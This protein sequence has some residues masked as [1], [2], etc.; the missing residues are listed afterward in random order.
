MRRTYLGPVWA[1]VRFDYR[2]ALRE[3]RRQAC[4]QCASSRFGG[5]CIAYFGRREGWGFFFRGASTMLRH[6][7]SLY[8]RGG[9]QMRLWASC[10]KLLVGRRLGSLPSVGIQGGPF[11]GASTACHARLRSWADHCLQGSRRRFS[12]RTPLAGILS[13]DRDRRRLPLPA[14]WALY[15]LGGWRSPGMPFYP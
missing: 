8:L 12:F 3:A 6:A 15:R 10:Q 14:P 13:Q 9:F 1:P 11:R 5:V 4:A 2:L 7:G